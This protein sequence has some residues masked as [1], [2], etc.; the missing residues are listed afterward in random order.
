MQQQAEEQGCSL[1]KVN[2]ISLN[3]TLQNG[4]CGQLPC[5]FFFDLYIRIPLN[6]FAHR[7]NQ[8]S[9]GGFG[10]KNE[11]C[12]LRDI[13]KSRCDVLGGYITSVTL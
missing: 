4:N 8:H 12:A 5:L 10:N 7:R 9:F 2:N 1:S 13:L 3:T 11:R 6:I